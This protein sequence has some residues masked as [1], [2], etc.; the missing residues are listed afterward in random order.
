MKLSVT[1]KFVGILVTL[2]LISSATIYF[3]ATYYYSNTLTQTLN[4]SIRMAQSNF[5]AITK[6]KQQE[7][8]YV[9]AMGAQYTGLAEA[10]ASGDNNT[11]KK[12]SQE[13][14]RQTGMS[15]VTITN[16]QGTVLARG[17]SDKAQ[18]SIA[19]QESVARALKGQASSALVQ[20]VEAVSMRASQPI[21][22]QQKIVG[23]ISMGD[24]LSS[25][26]YLDWLHGLLQV[27]VTFFKGD[28]RLMTSIKDAQGQR[29]I[30]TKLNNPLIERTVLQQ[31]KLYLGESTI[32][33]QKYLAAYWPAFDI[34]QKAIGMWFIGLPVSQVLQAESDAR[35]YTI[36]WASI[37]LLLMLALSIAVAYRFTSPIKKIARYAVKVSNNEQDAS[38][39][40]QSQDEFGLLA[41][42]LTGMVQKLKDQTHWYTS[43]LNALPI[44]V[45]V[46]DMDKNWLFVNSS[47]LEGSGKKLEDILGL[48][49][50]TR[51][52]NLCNT[53]DCGITRLEKGQGDAINVMPSGKVMQMR[54]SYLLDS[55]GQKIGHVEVGLD[56]SEQERIR[57]EAEVNTENV[58][59]ALVEQI[60]NVVLAL[61][62]AAQQLF[63]S[64]TSAEENARNTA[65]HM[66]D[67]TCAIE[68]MESTI[69]DV[70]R[71][72][73]QAALGATDTQ[74]QAQEGHDV[75]SLIV[76]DI[77]GV[78]TASNNLKVDMEKLS[79]H[80]HGIGAILNIIRDIA[81]QT[82][83]LALNA[84][85]EAAR[86]GEAG[87][88]FAV[89]AD[90]VRKLA[91]KSMDATKEVESAILVIQE[92]TAESGKTMETT[93]G[94]VTK[95]TAEV[96]KAGETLSDIVHLSRTA[97][98]EISAI[99][100]AS[101]QQAATT[102]AISRTVSDSNALAQNLANSMEDTAQIVREVSSQAA[103]LRNILQSMKK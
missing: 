85:I 78:Q 69:Q 65:S 95:A 71:G 93:S 99:A 11:V 51:G 39:H 102:S 56:I 22:L 63:A 10:I 23:T 75:M 20:G 57:Q 68:E 24:A 4:D 80:A 50:H 64:I 29:I 60:E 54:L 16:A 55:K 59:R 21:K 76:N 97:A 62:G 61:D 31:E 58:R 83:L 74:S 8:T 41:Q 9:A 38:L 89:V 43:V 84:A 12:I 5:A 26:K 34:G 44:N 72:A 52:G 14:M 48:P 1:Q 79:E 3:T 96:H 2:L 100:T 77:L 40:I 90:E 49:C 25:P 13:I 86:A 66:V 30:G 98:T 53:P 70:A 73:S 33:G 36:I 46:T 6:A 82:N 15:I 101:E 17:H 19:A 32:I 103:H 91:E 42:S 88:G 7:Y 47:G 45:S 37:V 35:T 67:V 87:R 92:R 94:A 28:T 27:Q 18:D 81:D